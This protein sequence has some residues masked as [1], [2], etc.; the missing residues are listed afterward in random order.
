MERITVN[1]NFDD[2]HPQADA[3][4]DF[5]GDLDQGVF[6]LLQSLWDEFPSLKIT[7]FTT[8]NWIDRPYLH[9]RYFYHIR[10]LL[11]MKPVV[12]PHRDEPF[13][14]DKHP[15]WCARV[16]ALV[17]EGKLEIAVHGYTHHNPNSVI[18]GQEFD[19]ITYA[20]AHQK[21]H[22]AEAMFAAVG[23]PFVKIFRPPGWGVSLGMYEALQDLKYRA[24]AVLPSNSR[25]AT[26]GT[27][28]GM[29]A[30]PSNYS[31]NE[32]PDIA[33]REV[34]RGHALFAK[35]HMTYRYGMETIH[36]GITASS[37][38]HIR[39]VLHALEQEYEVHYVGLADLL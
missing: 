27:V 38:E 3:D 37:V 13:R 8:P 9:H 6:A 34:R 30:I 2:F 7:F 16:A 29:S 11:G 4:G 5:G 23:I 28:N 26:I 10:K 15:A 31:L 39:T 18:H 32:S 33:L 1:L 35:G 12:P 17:K 14:L 25:T 19:E 20:D 22:D 24:V 21:I 36:N